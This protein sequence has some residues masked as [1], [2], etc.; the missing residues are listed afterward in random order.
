MLIQNRFDNKDIIFF[1]RMLQRELPDNVK[2]EITNIIF[3][4]YVSDDQ[5]SFARDLYLGEKE[6]KE[7]AKEGMFF[8]NHTHSH[9][10]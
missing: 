8:G 10:G 3:N 7:M 5:T 6:I 9:P 1:K 2:S 4:K